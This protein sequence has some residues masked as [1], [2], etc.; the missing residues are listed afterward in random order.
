MLLWMK[1]NLLS[2]DKRYADAIKVFELRKGKGVMK[3]W[4]LAYCYAKSEQKNKALQILNDQLEKSET[5]YV[6]PYMI[7]TIYIGLGDKERALD[8]LEKD[9]ETGGQGL[10][11]WGLKRDTKFESIRNEPRFIALLNNIK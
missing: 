11:V 9:F 4:M 6:P 8:W 7:A 5:T 10:F 3:N 1:G 2:G